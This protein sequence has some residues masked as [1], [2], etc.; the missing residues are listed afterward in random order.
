[1]GRDRKPK[2]RDVFFLFRVKV[3]ERE[4]VDEENRVRKVAVAK[5]AMNWSKGKEKERRRELSRAPCTVEER[6]FRPPIIEIS[7]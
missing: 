6:G 5:R 3:M 1:M 4:L 2:E 7:F